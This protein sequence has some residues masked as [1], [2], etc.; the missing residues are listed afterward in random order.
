M[1]LVS[2]FLDKKHVLDLLHLIAQ[3][4]VRLNNLVK[5][6]IGV[7]GIWDFEAEENM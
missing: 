4:A 3:E 1:L 6:E 2:L 7:D 5:R